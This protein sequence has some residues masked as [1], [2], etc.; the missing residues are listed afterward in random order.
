MQVS[1]ILQ[2]TVRVCVYGAM[3]AAWPILTYVYLV[4]V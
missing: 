1:S 2:I 4:F 3:I